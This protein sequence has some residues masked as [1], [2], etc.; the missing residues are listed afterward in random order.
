M[1]PVPSAFH[2]PASIKPQAKNAPDVRRP[3]PRFGMLIASRFCCISGLISSSFGS[4]EPACISA[5]LPFSLPFRILTRMPA[6]TMETAFPIATAGVITDSASAAD[7]ELLVSKILDS[8]VAPAPI[9][10]P[11]IGR[12]IRSSAFITG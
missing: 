11:M 10:P 9:P 12:A 2:A 5:P 1:I 6:R 4:M 7:M 3:I 8:G